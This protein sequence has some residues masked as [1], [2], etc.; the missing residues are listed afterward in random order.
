[1]HHT[2]MWTPTTFALSVSHLMFLHYHALHSPDEGEGEEERRE[3]RE[4]LERGLEQF[5]GRVGQCVQ[6]TRDGHML[7]D[8]ARVGLSVPQPLVPDG[9]DEGKVLCV[10]VRRVLQ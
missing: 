7:R 3:E 2:H 5:W 6:A 8:M 9:D 4:K 1:M 10:C